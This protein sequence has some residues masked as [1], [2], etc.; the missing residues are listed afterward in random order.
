MPASHRVLIT[1]A[2]GFLGRRMVEML[3]ERGYQV[4]ALVRKTSRIDPLRLPGVE[5]FYGD[6][7]DAQSLQPAFAGID[8]VVHAVADTSG[9]EAGA[10]LVTIQGTRN[11]LDLCASHPVRKLV[12]IS[13]CSVYG[14]AECQVGQ[15]V[16]ENASLERFPERR[17][18]YSWGKLAA[19]KLVTD[20]MARGKIP[21]VCLRPGTI[22]GC[23]GENYTPMLGFSFGDKVFAVIGDGRFVL[24]LVYVDNLV[25]AIR[26]AMLEDKSSGQIYTVVDPR[27]VDKKRYMDHF[28][29]KLH[30]RAS[31]LYVPYSLL[32][33]A[34]SVQEKVFGLLKRRPVMTLY[35]LKSSQNPIIYDPAKIM[36]ELNWHPLV[37]FEEAVQRI[38]AREQTKGCC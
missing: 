34:V 12:Y 27:Q 37:S 6:V 32:S 7:T 10:R 11:I 19:E 15:V 31:F 24:P 2:S 33:A 25:E 29:R 8:Y 16:D 36:Q 14:V 18:A 20:F 23:G 26:V 1:G 4:R 28:I 3:V 30:P 21:A 22:Y 17:G 9:T 13:S 5:I 35:R 38:I